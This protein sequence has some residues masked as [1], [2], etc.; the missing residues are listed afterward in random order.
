M[1][2]YLTS[3]IL[4]TFLFAQHERVLNTYSLGNSIGYT[5]WQSG[6]Q[7]DFGEELFCP[8]SSIAVGY[9]GNTGAWMDWFRLICRELIEDGSLGTTSYTGWNGE[10]EGGSFYGPYELNSEKALVGFQVNESTWCTDCL[11]SIQG[12]GQSI[13]H[14]AFGNENNSDYTSLPWLGPT[15]TGVSNIGTV[16]VPDGSVIVGMQNTEQGGYVHGVSW[17]FRNL[18]VM[19]SPDL[20]GD[21]NNDGHVNLLDIVLIVN[22]ILTISDYDPFADVN[23]DMAITI[24]DIMLI[25]DI[26]FES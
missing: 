6:G 23:G 10:S 17:I 20:M 25:I 3:V 7:T 1:I 11:A 12:Y 13:E 14:I 15:E 26:I 21:V 24:I 8:E 9:E 5:E 2:N 18:L 4:V 19:E 22:L 16:W